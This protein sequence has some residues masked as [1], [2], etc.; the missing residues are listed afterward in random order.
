MASIGSVAHVARTH[1][2]NSDNKYVYRYSCD[3]EDDESICTKRAPAFR[4]RL[5]GIF[6]FVCPHN[7]CL[8]FALMYQHE[9]PMH[10]FRI[11][12]ERLP[13]ANNRIVVIDNACNIHVYSMRREPW[14]FRNVWFLVDRLHWSNH[15]NCSRYVLCCY[16]MTLSTSY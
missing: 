3:S 6:L 14:F 7:I 12:F 13:N 11:L 8:G 2:S 10:P 4:L 5:P 16:L 1:T 15:I 9:S